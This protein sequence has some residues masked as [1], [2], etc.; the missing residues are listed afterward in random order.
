ML[1]SKS[2]TATPKRSESGSVPTTISAPILFAKAI[3]IDK[4]SGSSGFGDFT[5]GKSPSG[6]A[7][8]GTIFT[9]LYPAFAN[10]FGIDLIDVPCKEV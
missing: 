3:A 8:S 9:S 2:R 7:C 4:A 10:T 1:P 6:S 5:V